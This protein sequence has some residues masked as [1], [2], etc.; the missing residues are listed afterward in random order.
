MKNFSELNVVARESIGYTLDDAKI[1]YETA[2]SY[3]S[4]ILENKN[5]VSA[6]II[7]SYAAGN[8]TPSRS[9]IDFVAFYEGDKIEFS[10][11]KIPIILCKG[12]IERDINVSI[13][14][15]PISFVNYWNIIP[16]RL[17]NGILWKEINS[18]ED[19]MMI[20]NHGISV[21][22]N[23]ISETVL[24]YVIDGFERYLR[25]RAAL[26]SQICNKEKLF[27]NVINVVKT[28][29][30]LAR[31]AC[32]VWGGE[33]IY[34]TYGCLAWFEKCPDVSESAKEI[35][36]EAVEIVDVR[37]NEVIS[38]EKFEVQ[39]T[40][41]IRKCLKFCNELKKHE[42][43]MCEK[44]VMTEILD[45]YDYIPYNFPPCQNA[46]LRKIQAKTDG[47]NVSDVCLI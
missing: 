16:Q 28:I 8:F 46:F 45:M 33:Y 4:N 40:K 47:L 1:V 36:K 24:W 6:Y 7:G 21:L 27:P 5:A 14:L 34:S 39:L 43:F 32:F 23:D 3:A 30:S 18:Y 35:L 42:A 41:L 37:W 29:I 20:L 11:T 13:C 31:D 38:A 10:E 19:Y 22:E 2:A 9:D 15:R 25:F 12:Q 26:S 44:K 17:E